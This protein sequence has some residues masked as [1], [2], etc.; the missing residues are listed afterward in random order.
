MKKRRPVIYA[1]RN[2]VTGAAYI[3]GTW[4]Y[5]ARQQQHLDRLRSGRHP[6]HRLQAAWDLDGADAFEF[7]VLE[8]VVWSQDYRVSDAEQRHM[9]ACP[10]RYNAVAA[11][12]GGG[13]TTEEYRAKLRASHTPERE[14]RRK[15]KMAANRLKR[16]TDNQQ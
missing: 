11:Q 14:A 16:E 6:N 2:R 4:D 5:V 8:E 7:E 15:A 1:L 10:N 9:S 13:T 12:S 3:G